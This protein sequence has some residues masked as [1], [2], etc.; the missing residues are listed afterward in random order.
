MEVV[1][2]LHLRITGLISESNLGPERRF[3]VVS[4]Q[5]VVQLVKR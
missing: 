2:T 3:P 1:V 4:E 5:R